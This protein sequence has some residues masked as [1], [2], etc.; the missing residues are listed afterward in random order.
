M[1]TATS[2]SDRYAEARAALAQYDA[3]IAEPDDD[4]GYHKRVD[5]ALDCIEPLRAIIEP[6]TVS[7]PA[8]P[9]S[10]RPKGTTEMANRV[11]AR[12]NDAQPEILEDGEPH[13]VGIW[14]EVTIE[15]S[16]A[17]APG[18]LFIITR[19]ENDQMCVTVPDGAAF[20]AP[21][22][23]RLAGNDPQPWRDPSG[24]RFRSIWEADDSLPDYA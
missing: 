3:A 9:T 6:P 8:S 4:P 18:L 21:V 2:A 10:H 19:Y 14:E 16:S 5:A 17:G 13:N 11:L 7:S 24:E 12:A 22:N 15:R 20:L 1:T 23:G